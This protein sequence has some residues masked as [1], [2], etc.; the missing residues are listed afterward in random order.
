MHRQQLLLT[1][2]LLRYT[3]CLNINILIYKK[4]RFGDTYPTSLKAVNE[5]NYIH[6]TGCCLF[7][8]ALLG[9]Q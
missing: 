3:A 2:L 7:E 4:C 1:V 8:K 9:I 6:I 5:K